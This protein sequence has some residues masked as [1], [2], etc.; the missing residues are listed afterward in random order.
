MERR[1]TTIEPWEDMELDFQTRLF[2]Y[3]KENPIILTKFQ[4]KI[5]FES[6]EMEITGFNP[7]R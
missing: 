2:M 4:Q 5:I 3:N 1:K 6:F 7:F